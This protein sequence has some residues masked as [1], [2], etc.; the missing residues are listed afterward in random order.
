[1]RARGIEMLTRGRP[2]SEIADACR[3]S[4]RTVERWAALPAVRT[5]A[6]TGRRVDTTPWRMVVRADARR[7]AREAAVS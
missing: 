3:V 4:P 2:H 5:A 6:R 7:A 1:V